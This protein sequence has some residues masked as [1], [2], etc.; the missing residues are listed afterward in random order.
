MKQAFIF[1]I[2]FRSI[3][4]F[5]QVNTP[6]EVRAILKNKVEV[7]LDSQAT[8]PGGEKVLFSYLHHKF[9]KENCMPEKNTKLYFR[10]SMNTEGKIYK[11]YIINK[12]ISKKIKNCSCGILLNMPKWRPAYYMGNKIKYEF[13]IPLFF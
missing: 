1:V 3:Y 5:G 2:L 12:N 11:V 6:P 9:K 4:C 13:I 8:F 10:C 7:E